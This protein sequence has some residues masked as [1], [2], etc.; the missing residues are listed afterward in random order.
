VQMLLEAA[1]S[2]QWKED[3][4]NKIDEAL[5]EVERGDV[6]SWKK[7]DCARMGREYLQ[8]KRRSEAKL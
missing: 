7:G 1:I 3:T 4:E 8:E 6:A 5:A 2:R